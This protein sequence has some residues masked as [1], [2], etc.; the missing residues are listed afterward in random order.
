[1]IFFYNIKE[2]DFPPLGPII[3]LSRGMRRK[4]RIEDH[5]AKL[6]TS[7]GDLL[8]DDVRGNVRGSLFL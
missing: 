5:Q 3:I 2:M 8:L 6:T 7:E 4:I 1:M